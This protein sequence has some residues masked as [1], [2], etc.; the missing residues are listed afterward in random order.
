MKNFLIVTNRIKDVNLELTDRIKNYILS[1]GGQCEAISGV[2]ENETIEEYLVKSAQAVIV[3]GGDGTILRVSNI[4]L[5]YDIPIVGVNLGNVGFLAEVEENNIYEAVD[6]LFEEDYSI[7][8]RMHICG[9]IYRNS[10][11]IYEG[12][13]LNDIVITRAGY[14]RIIYL[15]VFVNGELLDT[16]GA[17]GIIVSTPTGSTGYNMSAGGPIV[18]PNTNLIIVTPVSPHSLSSKSI[19]FSSEDEITIEVVK[20]RQA[21]SEEVYISF[22]GRKGIP[23]MVGD[24]ITVGKS[25]ETTKLI[26]IYNVGFYEVLRKKIIN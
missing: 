17:D 1:K 4:L 11:V 22:D 13:S 10:E 15:K 7:E 26:R 24:K 14:S 3:L 20:K 19:V 25:H 9:S 16:Y 12:K 2:A 6:K 21:D 23:L 18:S 8:N 5:G